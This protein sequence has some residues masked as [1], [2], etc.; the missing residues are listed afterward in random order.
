MLPQQPKHNLLPVLAFACCWT[1]SCRPTVASAS[2]Q[3]TQPQTQTQTPLATPTPT[4]QPA[5]SPQSIPLTPTPTAAP[6]KSDAN[7]SPLNPFDEII[8]TAV[9]D[10]M[11]GTTFPDESTLPPN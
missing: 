3:G 8:I 5:A 2:A 4:P 10:V 1:F 6:Q 11:L 9:G 7:S